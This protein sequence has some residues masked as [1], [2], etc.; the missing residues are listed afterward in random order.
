[1]MDHSYDLRTSVLLG[2]QEALLE[3]VTP[4]LRGV[5]VGWS[6]ES[7]IARLYYDGA[8]STREGETAG[9]ETRAMS[10]ITSNPVQSLKIDKKL[11]LI[12]VKMPEK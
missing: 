7:I 10:E 1:M 6:E 5:T 2:F 12:I 9:K 3:M 8:L 11:S 4:N